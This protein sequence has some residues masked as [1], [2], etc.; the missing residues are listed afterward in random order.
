MDPARPRKLT[1]YGMYDP[2]VF[3]IEMADHTST[4]ASTTAFGTPWS[5][6]RRRHRQCVRP[7]AGS[8]AF[9]RFEGARQRRVNSAITPTPPERVFARHC[10]E[11]RS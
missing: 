7:S 8:V 11:R 5:A 10:V 9:L 6:R 2:L 1:G 3:D 4:M